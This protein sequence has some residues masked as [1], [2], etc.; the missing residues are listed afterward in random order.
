MSD[1][2]SLLKE[3]KGYY[4]EWGLGK[5]MSRVASRELKDLIE[6]YGGSVS[7]I[8]SNNGKEGS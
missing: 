6:R 1:L 5:W 7:D 8:P 3:L 4:W 2:E